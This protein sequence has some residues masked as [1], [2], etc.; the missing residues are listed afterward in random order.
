MKNTAKFKYEWILYPDVLARVDFM[1]SS[2]S[3][4]D[5]FVVS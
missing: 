5:S 3:S 4:K 1:K 2:V